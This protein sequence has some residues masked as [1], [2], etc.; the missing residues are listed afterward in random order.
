MPLVSG[1]AKAV[2]GGWITLPRPNIDWLNVL[3]LVWL[4][5]SIVT[6]ALM[7]RRGLLFHKFLRLAARRDHRIAGR[8]QQLA[9]S[10]GLATAPAVIVV[11]G[12]VSPMLWGL[13]RRVQLVFPARLADRLGA[14]EIDSLLLHELAHYSRGDY[15]VRLVELCAHVA[16]WW[17]PVV[18]WT[19]HEIEAAE[20]QCCDAW[21]VEHQ[22]GTPLTYAEALLTTIDFLCEAAQ[23]TKQLTAALPPAAC[24]LGDVPLLRSRLTQIMR[25]ELGGQ[26]PRRVWI[27][28]L[29][30]G[31]LISPL[32][33]A[34]FA[35]SSR[36][37]PF[38]PP[39][40]GKVLI[41]RAV[42]SS[43]SEGPSNDVI[44]T[45]GNDTALPI[46][47]SPVADAAAPAVP[48]ADIRPVS[49]IFAKAQSPDGRYTLEAGTNYET[50][51]VHPNLRLGLSSNQITSAAFAPD[52]RSFVTGHD[53]GLLRL[54][55]SETGVTLSKFRALA[56]AIV[57]V[58]YSP[59]GDQ[60]AAGA[61]DGT[62]VVWDVAAQAE[63]ARLDNPGIAV[64]SLRWSPSGDRL[65][66]ALGD[67]ASNDSRLMIWTPASNQI[68]EQT[69]TQP[70]GAL[71]WLTGDA[72][73][74]ADWNGG[75]TVRHLG[76]DRPE[77]SL[78]VDKDIVSAAHWSP[79][80]R[81]ITTWRADQ[82]LSEAAR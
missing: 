11:D 50:T 44:G 63:V 20:E 40:T 64:S 60:I 10:V 6:A 59:A 16:Y 74:L 18:W 43:E 1:E 46:E 28:V 80:C 42:K 58:A 23:P 4:A 14:A 26:L 62:L 71:D 7:L 3:G 55:D 41:A 54:W 82:L 19:R 30:G 35:T 76:A 77:Q 69:L 8:V 48:V 72:L 45:S 47:P 25:G 2:S 15:W 37:R 22:S 75:A 36:E 70:I 12:V 32:E 39:P 21:V 78:T 65:A 67:W 33:P 53:D 73:L 51:L 61:S 5:G 13:G 31:L 27:G 34:V 29:I 56:G 66:V 49:I 81:L 17:H 52:S 38:A 68:S 24:G 79:A 9:R 57:S